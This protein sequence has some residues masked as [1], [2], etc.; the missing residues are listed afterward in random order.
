MLICYA[1]HAEL[2][3]T[4]ALYSNVKD[5]KLVALSGSLAMCLI[6]CQHKP[7]AEL[8]D[9]VVV[10]PSILVNDMQVKYR[11]LSVQER[12]VLKVTT[13]YTGRVLASEECSLTEEEWD[14]L[15]PVLRA[16]LE[17]RGDLIDEG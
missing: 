15:L 13:G 6:S 14:K 17:N 2:M 8:E 10:D 4:L 9:E 11:I 12:R 7:S 1:D 5:S 16:N 3:K